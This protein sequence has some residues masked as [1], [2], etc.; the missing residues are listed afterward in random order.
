MIKTALKV[1]TVFIQV[2]TCNSDQLVWNNM[3]FSHTERHSTLAISSDV[4]G[5]GA[6]LLAQ[7]AGETEHQNLGGGHTEGGD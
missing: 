1:S 4:L 6:H 2:I 3:K 7:A 5:L